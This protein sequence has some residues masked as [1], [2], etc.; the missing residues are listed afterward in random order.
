[1][2]LLS[3][4][5]QI[6]QN[7]KQTLWLTNR[8]ASGSIGMLLK[9]MLDKRVVKGETLTLKVSKSMLVCLSYC[10]KVM[11]IFGNTRALE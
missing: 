3:H 2:Y 4:E 1:M 7:Q 5:T 11:V 8:S 9:M 10:Q 6:I